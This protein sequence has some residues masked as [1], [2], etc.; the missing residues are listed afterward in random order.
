[1]KYEVRKTSYGYVLIINREDGTVNDYRF[2]TKSE[3]NRWAK[4]AGI[5]I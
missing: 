1:M 5:K 2:N 3:L 4:S